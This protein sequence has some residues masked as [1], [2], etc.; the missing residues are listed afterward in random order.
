MRCW[1]D[2]CRP[3]PTGFCSRRSAATSIDNPD[4]RIAEDCREF[5]ESLLT[6]VLDFFMSLIGLYSFV[7]LLWQLSTFPLAFELFG[8]AFEIPRYMVWAAPDLR[9]DRDRADARPRP[10][11]CRACWPSSSSARRIF[12]SH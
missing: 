3:R 11:R 8:I 6:K 1:T 10:C 12:A 9:G 4:Q 5:V 7:T 2:G